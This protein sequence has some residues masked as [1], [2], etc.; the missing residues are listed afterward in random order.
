MLHLVSSAVRVGQWI[1]RGIRILG[2]VTRFST[3]AM[4]LKQKKEE[5]ETKRQLLEQKHA[6]RMAKIRQKDSS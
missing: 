5:Q 3:E 6:E 4:K 1:D 2:H